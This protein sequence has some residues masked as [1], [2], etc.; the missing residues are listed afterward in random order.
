M[1]TIDTHVSS[2]PATSGSGLACIADWLTTTDHKRIGRLYIGTG[3]F[4]FLATAVVALLLGIV[5]LFNAGDGETTVEAP[6]DPPPLGT[7]TSGIGVNFTVPAGQVAVFEIVTRRDNATVPIPNHCGYVMAADEPLEGT[8]RW[9]HV[10]EDIVVEGGRRSWR[11]EVRY[12]GGGE[13]STGGFLLPAGLDSAVGTK[14]LGLGMLEP[15][16]E[17]ISWCGNV[18]ATKLPESGLV[19]VRVTAVPHG[20]NKSGSGAGDIDWK[21]EPPSSTTRRKLP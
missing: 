1:T 17:I 12:A 7:I 3:A 8:F 14:S 15:S 4:A 20:L 18:D 19:G 10:P 11:I 2:A 13:T 6:D 9:S 16:A 5:A 21:T